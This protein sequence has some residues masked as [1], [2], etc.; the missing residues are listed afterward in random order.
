MKGEIFMEKYEPKSFLD[1]DVLYKY[2]LAMDKLQLII[3]HLNLDYSKNL[4]INPI[5]HMKFRIKKEDSIRQKLN[6]K[7]KE[8]SILNIDDFV[9]DVVGARIVCPFLSDVERV[10]DDLRIHPELKILVSKD[11]INYPKTNGY[12]SYHLYVYVPVTIDGKIEYVRAEIQIRT[13]AMDMWACLD[14]KIRYKK[15]I[16]LSYED[17]LLMSD[18]AMFCRELDYDLNNKYLKQNNRVKRIKNIKN[19][20]I[21]NSFEFEKMTHRYEDAMEQVLAKINN[22]KEDYDTDEKA[23]IDVNPI[24]HIKSR[25]KPIDRMMIKLKKQTDDI[26]IKSLEE[27]VNDIAGIRIVCSFESDLFK[28]VNRLKDEYAGNILREKDYVNFP[29]DSG[30]AGYHFT[31]GIP[32]NGIITKVEVQVRTIAMDMW[33]S[34]EHNLC[35]QKATDADSKKSLLELAYIRSDVDERMEQVIEESRRLSMSKKR[36]KIK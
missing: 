1:D 36:I 23:L 2:K 5:E 16:N 31:L 26:S 24:E 21:V 19:D 28:I 10:I 12:S 29:K 9:G 33:A 22:W 20:E 7:D 15:G 32:I 17:N 27:H 18:T 25:I 35:Y 30:Y 34:L 13:M 3:N 6:K 14:H 4:D 8:Y 11:Y